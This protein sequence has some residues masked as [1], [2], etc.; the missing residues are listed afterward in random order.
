MIQ[1]RYQDGFSLIA[2]GRGDEAGDG[3]RELGVQNNWPSTRSEANASSVDATVDATKLA[4][5]ERVNTPPSTANIGR[6]N[7]M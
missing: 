2:C 1:I 5:A 4:G 7:L 6:W 3:A